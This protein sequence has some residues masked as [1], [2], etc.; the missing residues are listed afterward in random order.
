VSLSV[1]QLAAALQTVL[2]DHA[3]AR[4]RPTGFLRRQGKLTAEAFVQGLV[5]GWLDDPGA[6]LEGL[7]EAIAAA[8][9][10]D[11]TPQALDQRFTPAAA[12][13]LR[14]VLQAALGHV[15]AATPAAVPLLRR[16]TGV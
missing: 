5:F 10:A 14:D 16:F 8:G 6:P 3:R 11:V 4:A 15:F 2:T 9:G 7:A 12:N 1:P 13:L